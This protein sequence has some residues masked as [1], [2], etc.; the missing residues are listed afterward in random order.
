MPYGDAAYAVAAK[1]ETLR[2]ST[3]EVEA[4]CPHFGPCGGCALQNLEYPSQ[5]DAKQ[6]Q[7]RH[8][9]F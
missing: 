7:V 3:L 4:P 2:P 6:A 5:L 9:V 1:V 8:V